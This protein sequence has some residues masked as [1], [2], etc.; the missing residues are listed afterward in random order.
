MTRQ[1]FHEL[2]ERGVVERGLDGLVDFDLARHAISNRMRPGSKSARSL[3][4]VERR[5]SR[6]DLISGGGPK[7]ASEV[8][9][10]DETSYHVA[11]TA[12]EAAEAKIAQLKLAQM[13]GDLID[14]EQVRKAAFSVTRVVRDQLLALPSRVA[15]LLAAENSASACYDMLDRELRQVLQQLQQLPGA[16]DRQQ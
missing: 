10:F 4:A 5:A 14:R 2:I 12:R 3:D 6:D 7:D 11:K 1:S 8:S 16:E 15:P 13:R 9:G